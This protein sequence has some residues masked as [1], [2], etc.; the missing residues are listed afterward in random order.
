M[1]NGSVSQWIT[2]LKA[3]DQGAAELIW[4]RYVERLLRLARRRLPRVVCRMADEEDVVITAFE[5][6]CRN[7]AAGRFPQLN[8]RE[9]LWRMLLDITEKKSLDH[10]KH[11]TRQKRGGGRIRGESIFNADL[12]LASIESVEDGSMEPTPEFATEFAEC[13]QSMMSRL[14]DKS[15]CEIAVLKLEGYDNREISTRVGIS[16]R[17][18]V[19]KLKV[20]RTVWATHYEEVVEA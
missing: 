16:L 1:C 8:D 13:L 19:R 6:F 20:V 12:G 15:L 14:R 10:I 17:S 5:S 2:Q 3:G 11:E 4:H 18:V 9:G 7:A